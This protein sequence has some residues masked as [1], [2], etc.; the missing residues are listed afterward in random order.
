MRSTPSP[1]IALNR[2]VAVASG[3]AR[4][5]G[6]GARGRARGGLRRYH[7]STHAGRPAARLGRGR[8]AGRPTS[9]RVGARGRARPSAASSGT[10]RERDLQSA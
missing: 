5:A 2:A 9:V 4:S 1:V 10:P 8:G 7:L 6:L 3:A